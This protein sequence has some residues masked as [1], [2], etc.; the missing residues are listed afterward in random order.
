ML[1]KYFT[2]DTVVINELSGVSHRNLGREVRH[3]DAALPPTE[4]DMPF[5]TLYMVNRCG[6]IPIILLNTLHWI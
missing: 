5:F 3:I 1:K 4:L 6:I 2:D